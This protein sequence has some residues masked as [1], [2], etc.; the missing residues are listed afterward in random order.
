[1]KLVHAVRTDHGGVE[2]LSGKEAGE[3]L[4]EPEMDVRAKSSSG[5]ES[6][7][8]KGGFRGG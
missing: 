5:N 2:E 4:R 1:M 3:Q 8:E 7:L 6:A